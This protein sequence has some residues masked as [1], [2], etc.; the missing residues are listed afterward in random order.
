MRN[1]LLKPQ[2]L[3][4]ISLVLGTS[5]ATMSKLVLV[6]LGGC[7]HHHVAGTNLDTS[8]GVDFM[9]STEFTFLV[10]L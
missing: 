6:S 5:V 4:I 9:E 10:Q 1:C 8:V 7:E 2:L 3:G